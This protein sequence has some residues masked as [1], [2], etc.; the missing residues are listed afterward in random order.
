MREIFF[1]SGYKA[2]ATLRMGG[3]VPEVECAVVVVVVSSGGGGE[4]Y[5]ARCGGR[6]HSKRRKEGDTGIVILQ[7]DVRETAQI[8][9]QK[10]MRRR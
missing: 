9:Y 1:S 4:P 10:E 3:G 8:P 6:N 5:V 7:P 2:P